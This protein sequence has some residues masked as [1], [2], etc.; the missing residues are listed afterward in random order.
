MITFKTSPC[1]GC[2]KPI[3]WGE[4]P[5]GKKIPLDPTPAVYLVRE[6]SQKTVVVYRTLNCYMVTHFATCPKANQFSGS[7]KK[8]ANEP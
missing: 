6:E 2:G 8:E 7:K 4:T 1:R 3:V 5:D